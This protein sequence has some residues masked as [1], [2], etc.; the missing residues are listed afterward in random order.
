MRTTHG[1]VLMLI[2]SGLM[3]FCAADGFAQRVQIEAAA[4][5][6]F[7]V[8]R[9]IIPATAAMAG[10]PWAD[11]RI[12]LLER[13]GRALY[14]ALMDG[15][16]RQIFRNLVGVRRQIVIHFLF[17]GNEA[18]ELVVKAPDAV[19]LRALPRNV[20]A[21]RFRG[22]LTAW[23]REY[24]RS[25]QRHVR[26]GDYPGVIDNYL[27]SM[28]AR[29]LSLQP[30]NLE[31]RGLF[32]PP[33]N[34]GLELLL[35]TE[36]M[37]GRIQRR[38]LLMTAVSAAVL[39]PAPAEPA[40]PAIQYP[41][42]KEQVGIEPM[43]VAVPEAFF[44]LRC[45]TYANY[46]WMQRIMEEWGEVRNMITERGVDHGIDA[47]IERLLGL[48]DT[49]LS[50]A[51]GGTIISDVAFVGADPFLEEGPAFGMLF[52]AANNFLVRRSLSKQRNDALEKEGEDAKETTVDID[53]QKVSFASSPDGGLRSYYAAA[54][55]YHLVTTS[56]TMM[57]EF[58][59]VNK[60]R[61][62]GSI[63]TSSGF[64]YARSLVPLERD[65]TLLLYLSDAFFRRLAS[66]PYRIEMARRLRSV[67][68]IQSLRLA[69]LAAAAEGR[70]GGTIAD[71]IASDML[72]RGF[73]RRADG[74]RILVGDDGTMTDSLRGKPG[75]YVPVADMVLGQVRQ[76]E[77]AE[78][79]EFVRAYRSSPSRMD[80]MV[81]GIKRIPTETPGL[82][83][84]S[85]DAH[86][87][88]LR[89]AQFQRISQFLGT[90]RTARMSPLPGELARID[91]IGP[92][93]NYLFFRV[94]DFRP[95]LTVRDGK[96]QWGLPN[97]ETLRAY[98]GGA[99][100]LGI[101]ESLVSLI[102][103][104]PENRRVAGYTQ[105]PLGLW[106]WTDAGK[107]LFSFK[108]EVID[109]VVPQLRFVETARPAQVRIDID[110][111]SRREIAWAINAYGYE[112]ARKV[113]IGNT[114][115]L[116]SLTRQVHA[117]RAE[118]MKIAEDLIGAKLVCALQGKYRQ[119]VDSD[120]GFWISTAWS[121]ANRNALTELPADYVFP[122]LRW[123]RGMTAE[124]VAQPNILSLHAELL[125]QRKPPQKG[126]AWPDFFQRPDSKKNA[127]AE[128]AIPKI[129]LPEFELPDVKLPDA[130]ELPPP[131]PA[132]RPAPK[133]APKKKPAD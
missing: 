91:G 27:T 113:S 14:P 112:H 22:L 96:V 133:K 104:R 3:A 90:P 7:G 64:R 12:D 82:E 63:G 83:A 74:S 46:V 17:T 114:A 115:F 99:P 95:P 81:V 106:R 52:E 124:L 78:Y 61:G 60:A 79:A 84:I 101:I 69:K 76:S 129:E 65:D 68:E 29:R 31:R 105:L 123:F 2:F 41:A 16:V 34:D 62:K 66:P 11:G 47:K 111:L 56:K 73:G 77:V 10:D 54:G 70:P 110:D 75:L 121:G 94:Q 15:P 20:P 39:R 103:G 87:A 67:A 58:L 119:E 55:D 109:G 35:G 102:S 71:L 108:R 50:R 37:L 128:P 40:W 117:P 100:S 19:P 131:R 42:V 44:Y 118:A 86:I 127:P 18:L 32:T 21:G 4:G 89:A 107:I 49:A 72:P 97:Y 1:R 24:S 43:A 53:G 120:A 98:L 13:N 36:R 57:G 23:W 93:N 25:A 30:P 126:I 38:D 80:P 6:P 125:M 85:I 48:E 8:G 28:L 132:P 130:E 9:V 122:V 5:S 26:S 116:Q 45:G 88:P 92:Q 51:F 33:A 59:A